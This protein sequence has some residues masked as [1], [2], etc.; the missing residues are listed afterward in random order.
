[1]P[2]Q[3]VFSILKTWYFGFKCWYYFSVKC[4]WIWVRW[5]FLFWKIISQLKTYITSLLFLKRNH[6]FD[7][8]KRNEKPKLV[9]KNAITNREW[10]IKWKVTGWKY[11]SRDVFFGQKKLSTKEKK[12]VYLIWYFFV[13]EGGGGHKNVIS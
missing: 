6:D 3:V 7:N 11:H 5:F 8:F 12:R 13:G 1:M 9:K 10:K 4:C 2:K